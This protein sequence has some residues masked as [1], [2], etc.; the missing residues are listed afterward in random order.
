[1]HLCGGR[2]FVPDNIKDDNQ[3]PCNSEPTTA[4]S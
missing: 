3:A 2:L 1:M 4:A